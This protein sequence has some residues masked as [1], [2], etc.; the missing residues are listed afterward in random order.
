MLPLAPGRLSI[1]NCCFRDSLSACPIRRAYKSVPP[2]GEDGTMNFTGLDGHASCAATCAASNAPAT[3]MP[4]DNQALFIAFTPSV[5]Q[6]TRPDPHSRGQNIALH[7]RRFEPNDDVIEW[8]GAANCGLPTHPLPWQENF[9]IRSAA[10][11]TS[12]ER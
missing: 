8:P 12:C 1:T 2:P 7:P 6:P 9:R 11:W 10:T 4:A 5:E 3:A